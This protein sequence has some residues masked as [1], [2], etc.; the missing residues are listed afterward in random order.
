M[1][2]FS[3]TS[4][5][6]RSGP[7]HPVAPETA[8]AST[9][10]AARNVDTSPDAPHAIGATGPPSAA[11]ALAAGQPSAWQPSAGPLWAAP[12]TLEAKAAGEG[13][14]LAAGDAAVTS[15]ASPLTAPT[16]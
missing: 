5:P 9:A 1:V 13:A 6:W 12:A 3:S 15:T 4:T 7:D 2:R 16:P 11:L 8:A 14:G 10:A